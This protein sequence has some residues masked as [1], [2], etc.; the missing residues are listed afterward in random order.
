[1]LRVE[2]FSR[3]KAFTPAVGKYHPNGIA[4]L[5]SGAEDLSMLPQTQCRTYCP[6]YAKLQALNIRFHTIDP[7]QSYRS[8]IKTPYAEHTYPPAI[9]DLYPRF[10]NSVF[11]V[12][13]WSPCIII[14]LSFTDPP[15][16]QRRFNSVAR[17]FNSST[18][19]WKPETVVTVLPL[20]PLTSRWIRIM[21]SYVMFVWDRDCF[22]LQVHFE[23][24][25]WHE[26]QIL[27]VSVEYTN[28]EFF[29]A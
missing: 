22:F 4:S 23:T 9:L 16:P 5:R 14:T 25:F 28:F 6:V 7:G 17:V 3:L 24:G 8:S 21:P 13:R 27:P 15:V 10:L 1:M 11:K 26:E 2:L 18:L 19:I 12:S 20:R 29:M